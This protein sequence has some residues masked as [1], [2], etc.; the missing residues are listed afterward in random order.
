MNKLIYKLALTATILCST[1]QAKAIEPTSIIIG[2]MVI[3]AIS[4]AVSDSDIENLINDNIFQERKK[5]RVL[6]ST[7]KYVNLSDQDPKKGNYAVTYGI[8]AGDEKKPEMKRRGMT[9]MVLPTSVDNEYSIVISSINGFDCHSD[10]C[11]VGVKSGE[12]GWVVF[13]AMALKNQ[14]IPSLYIQDQKKLL[15]LINKH[16]KL[17]FNIAQNGENP[18]YWFFNRKFNISNIRSIEKSID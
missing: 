14:A 13:D 4:E 18:T 8:M 11:T 1:I 17:L 7:W 3:G 5:R 16:K 10:G 2:G 9:L 15:T 12:E 6:K